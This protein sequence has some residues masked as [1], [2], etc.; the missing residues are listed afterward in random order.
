MR[1]NNDS[2]IN[3]LN[4]TLSRLSVLAIA[5]M[6]QVPHTIAV[7]TEGDRCTQW[8][9]LLQLTHLPAV[10][11]GIALEGGILFVLLRGWHLGSYFFALVSV[12]IN[13]AYFA[14]GHTGDAF[15]LTWIE[16]LK[17]VIIPVVIAFYSHLLADSE[18]AIAEPVA[19]V[20]IWQRIAAKLANAKALATSYKPFSKALQADLQ[21]PASIDASEP[22]PTT[23]DTLQDAA[24]DAMESL[25]DTIAAL[26]GDAKEKYLQL[27]KIGKWSNA[28]VCKALGVPTGT[29]ASWWSRTQLQ[30]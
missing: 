25:Q 19:S 18:I 8:S 28:Q 26:Q 21:T 29:G 16:V 1:N 10:A 3:A 20:S 17:S 15:L 14:L 12:A 22:E 27:R 23:A 9:C 24:A 30:G 5:F 2:V 11:A 6:A 13:V 7:F 4:T